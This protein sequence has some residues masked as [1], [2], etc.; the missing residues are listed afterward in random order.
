MQVIHASCLGV[1]V[2]L[3]VNNLDKDLST[4]DSMAA[5]S[6]RTWREFE[7]FAERNDGRV[8]L[9]D[10]AADRLRTFYENYSRAETEAI[11][12]TQEAFWRKQ[13]KQDVKSD[14]RR[15]EHAVDD[16]VREGELFEKELEA[17][18]DTVY[19]QLGFKYQRASRTLSAIRSAW[20]VPVASTGW[21]NVD[22]AVI[23]ATTTR[24]SMS[25]TDPNSAKTATL[26]YAPMIV[27]V[28]DR[29][30]YDELVVYLI[31]NQLNS[32]Q[33]MKEGEGGFSEKL[34]SI[35]NYDLFC[36]GV[37]GKQQFAFTTKASGRSE[38]TVS[39]TATDDNRLRTMLRTKGN[40]EEGLLN[41]GRFMAWS[42]TE[43]ARRRS[44]MAR[45]E[46]RNALLGVVFPC[47]GDLGMS[48]A[49]AIPSEAAQ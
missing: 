13:W 46:L 6:E 49:D 3:Y 10:H 37:K 30:S 31:P 29:A 11:R 25:Y 26:T 48:A 34:N 47:A 19:A 39:L 36:L 28:E 41:E 22:I 38:I 2:D 12:R 4:I 14:T 35:F 5:G 40:V 17:N 33:R 20:V 18:M 45:Q 32:Y 24:T 23:Q 9:P 27:E 16:E 42:A 7:H 1:L 15:A 8:Q 44:N 43:N 21:W